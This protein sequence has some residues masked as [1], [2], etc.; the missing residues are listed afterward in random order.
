MFGHPLEISSRIG[1]LPIPPTILWYKQQLEVSYVLI[2]PGKSSIRPTDLF[3]PWDIGS[4][5]H[6]RAIINQHLRR[7]AIQ[8]DDCISIWGASFSLG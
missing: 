3:E 4:I 5:G 1:Y 8:R 2:I 6:C 7:F